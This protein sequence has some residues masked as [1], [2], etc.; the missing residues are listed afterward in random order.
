M[1]LFESLYSTLASE[2][3]K[4]QATGTANRRMGNQAINTAP[5]N[6]YAC[7]DGQFLALSASVQSMFENLAQAIGRPE[8][9]DDRRF[10]T[11]E[12]R[13]IHCQELKKS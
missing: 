1:A 2:A 6:I 7:A 12:D 5:R 8:L 9:I 10:L 4:F 3:V 11:N 13:V